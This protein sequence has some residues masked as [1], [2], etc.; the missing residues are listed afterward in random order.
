MNADQ[1][2]QNLTTKDTKEH[3]GDCQKYHDCRRSPKLKSNTKNL[4]LMSTDQEKTKPF[5]RGGTEEAEET[6]LPQIC[7][8]ER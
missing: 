7:A 4:P 1:E 5:K 6:H 3:K 2:K 8:D